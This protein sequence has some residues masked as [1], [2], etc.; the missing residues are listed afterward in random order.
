MKNRISTKKFRASSV[1]MMVLALLCMWPKLTYSQNNIDTVPYCCNF[2]E[3][4][5]R[6][7]WLFANDSPNDWHI[8]S[9][10]QSGGMYSMYISANGGL[11]NYCDFDASVSYAYRRLRIPAGLY[12]ISFDWAFLP[13]NTAIHAMITYF[14]VF[15]VPDT[16]TFTAGTLLDGLSNLKL[17][18]GA[19]SVD[20]S[21]GMCSRSYWSRF[22]N[23]HVQVPV[24]DNYYLV[25]CFVRPFQSDVISNPTAIDSICITPVQCHKPMALSRRMLQNGCVQLSWKDFNIPRNTM[26]AVEYGPIGFPHGH[27]NTVACNTD[28][29]TICGLINDQIYD[30]YVSTSCGNSDSTIY[31]DVLRMRY[32]DHQNQCLEFD[33][34]NSPNVICT[35]GKYLLFNSYDN[36]YPGPYADTGVIDYGP[37]Y[38]GDQSLTPNNSL[39]TVHTDPNETD[40]NT[41][42]RLHTVPPNECSSVRLGSTYGKWICQSI[43]Y[44]ILV[45]TSSADILIV[46]YACVLQNPSGHETLRKPRFILQIL[47]RYGV[48]TDTVCLNYDFS[49]NNLINDTT[50]QRA[51]TR[52]YWKDWTRA[53]INLSNYHGQPLTIRLTTFACGQGADDHFG[54]AYFNLKCEKSDITGEVCGNDTSFSTAL[55]KAPSGFSYRWYS[56][57]NPNF[58]S[59]NQAIWVPLDNSVYHCDIFLGDPRCKFT[60]AIVASP[61]NVERR[62]IHAN[63]RHTT[64]SLSCTHRLTVVNTSHSSDQNHGNIAYDCDF[65]LW[66]FGDNTTSSDENPLSHIYSGIGPYVVSLIAGRTDIGCYDTIVD[67]I[68]F[69]PGVY[70]VIRADICEDSGYRFFNQVLTQSGIYT[71]LLTSDNDCDTTIELHLKVRKHPQ[72]QIIGNNI[73]CEKTSGTLLLRTNG[74]DI[75]WTSNPFDSTLLGHE[76]DTLIV[77]PRL[78]PTLYTVIVDSFP[79]MSD[80]NASASIWV[81]PP[82]VFQ[83]F[84]RM[85]P[86]VISAQRMQIRYSD[87]SKGPISERQWTFHEIPDRF[88]DKEILNS[89]FVYY[90]P[91]FESDSLHV[92]LIVRNEGNCAD[93]LQNTYPILKG[94]VWV[95]SVFTPDANENNVLKVGHYN[96]NTYDISIYNRS[97]QRVFHSS[98]PD[99]C[100]DGTYNG[101]PCPAAAYVYHINYTTKSLPQSSCEQNGSVLIVR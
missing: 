57:D 12:E 32:R 91:H 99:E 43:S 45:D 61:N 65:F 8:G 54:Y 78:I 35:H 100:W 38:Y 64:D 82:P 79:R 84:Y 5:E 27:G 56:P 66:D 25:F 68:S 20:N 80:C 13:D 22:T 36:Y 39:H 44:N 11:D 81:N 97:G 60:K 19:I 94:E 24:T 15:L 2:E 73:S 40:Y 52:T 98:D 14:R 4:S 58:S 53:G 71:K 51:G 23:P 67:T 95:P 77:V 37:S 16:T 92:R 50:W 55:F 93:T 17:P 41:G 69:F 29:V 26:W 76:H 10:I 49:G 70:N 101:H 47:D 72:I 48:V 31:S 87:Y 74:N 89:R 34:I 30:F 63:F 83:A 75:R 18:E 90:T 9:A 21:S 86:Q 33:D 96:I 46:Q 88:D 85:S 1:S 59:S 62:F 7:Q 3:Y 42:G 6:G 28:T